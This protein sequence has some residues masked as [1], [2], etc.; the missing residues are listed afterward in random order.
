MTLVD[1]GDEDRFCSCACNNYRLNRMLHKHFFT[2][3]DSSRSNFYNISKLFLE[4]PYINLNSAL[5]ERKINHKTTLVSNTEAKYGNH[6]EESSPKL[7]KNDCPVEEVNNHV[8]FKLPL[9]QSGLKAVKMNFWTTLKEL[10]SLSYL[11]KMLKIIRKKIIK[12]KL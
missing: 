11:M 3:I 7:L 2:A 10:Y 1:F 8:D 12:K 4:H 9:Q 5:F 6:E